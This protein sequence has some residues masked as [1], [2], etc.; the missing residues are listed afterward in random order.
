[1]ELDQTA[2][3]KRVKRSK[4]AL[5][6]A[7]VGLVLEQGYDAVSV[8]AL[9]ERADVTRATF[10]THFGTKANLLTDVVDEFAGNVAAAFEASDAIGSDGGRLR[11]LLEYAG[12]WPDVL[13]II[14]RGEGDGAPLRR[15]TA[16]IAEVLVEDFDDELLE[17]GTSPQADRSL[18]VAMWASALAGAVRWYLEADEPSEPVMTANDVNAI[19]ELGWAWAAGRP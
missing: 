12:K 4:A 10:Y 14:V 15:F 19:A 13:T 3:D 9:A 6:A 11:V 5:R 8:D 1:M 18:V 17:L 2:E 7:M 16:R